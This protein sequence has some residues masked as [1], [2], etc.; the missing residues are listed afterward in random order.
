MRSEHDVLVVGGGPAGA[1]CAAFCAAAGLRVR[2][3]ERAV[4]PRDKVCG[5]CLNPDAWPVL[6]RL[7]L[8]ERVR[9]LPHTVLRTVEFAGLRGQPVRL[10]LPEIVRGEIA[11]KRRDL[12]ALLLG[13]AAEL[14][15]DVQQGRAVSAVRREDGGGYALTTTA[16][17]GGGGTETVRGRFLVAAD[18]RNS[19]IARL[20]GL[21]DDAPRRADARVGLQAHVP[22]PAGFGAR[23][24][25]KWF[26][27]GYG[28]CARWAG[29]S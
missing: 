24:Q 14:G 4:F 21:L 20:T 6:A 7:G 2:V 10:P 5:D 9:A 11:V 18:G 1:S 17:D 16:A 12:D 3:V 19:I 8:E 26:A 28:G 27:D 15:A 22:C 23:V 25:M 29:A 13:R